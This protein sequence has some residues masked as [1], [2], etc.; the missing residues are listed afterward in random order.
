MKVPKPSK[1][2][3]QRVGIT[4]LLISLWGYSVH[5]DQSP[6]ISDLS[7]FEL[8]HTLSME[9]FSLN[10]S[11]SY[12]SLC[13]SLSF[14]CD[15]TSKTWA[16]LSPKTSCVRSQLKDSGFKSQSEFHGFSSSWTRLLFFLPKYFFLFIK[17]IR[18]MEDFPG[19]PVT[20]TVLEMQGAQVSSLV[21]ELNPTCYSEDLVQPNQ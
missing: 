5:R 16:S 7:P 21:G 15:E 8:V 12:L 13:A 10:K 2:S 4:L 19:G 20:K 1:I 17:V 9:C 11:T 18:L 3:P 6:H 14:F